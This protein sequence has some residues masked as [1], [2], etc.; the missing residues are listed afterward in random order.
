MAEGKTLLT[1][2]ENFSI[3]A[4]ASSGIYFVE[5]RSGVQVIWLKFTVVH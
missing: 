2:Q 5:I 4:P 3:D 1:A